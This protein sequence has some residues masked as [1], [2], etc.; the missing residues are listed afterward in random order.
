MKGFTRSVYQNAKEGA[1][2]AA[3]IF[4]ATSIHFLGLDPRESTLR[5]EVEVDAERLEAEG[6]VLMPRDVSVTLYYTSE[7]EPPAQ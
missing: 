5:F 2:S 4:V 6:A 1:E 7:D 3:A